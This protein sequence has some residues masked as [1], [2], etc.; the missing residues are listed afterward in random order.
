MLNILI[1]LPGS[2][3]TTYAKECIDKNSNAI[4]I[5]SDSIRK[6]LYGDES[7][8]GN[9][10]EV[11]SLMETRTIETLKNEKDVYYDAT[12]MTRKDRAHIISVCKDYEIRAVVV[13]STYETCVERDKNRNR[14]VGED[15]IKRMMKRFQAP[16]YDEG[17]NDITVVNTD[18]EVYG[19]SLGYLV[20]CLNNM[21]ISHDNPHHILSIQ[22]HCTK[23]ADYIRTKT[24]SKTLIRAALYHDIGKP[25][26]KD[27]HDTHGNECEIAH[28][29]CHEN[30]SAWMVYGINLDPYMAWLVSSHMEP[31]KNS[32]YYRK[33]SEVMKQ[34]LDLLHEADEAAH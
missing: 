22:E 19:D 12:N 14:T 20:N 10:E 28:Y 16:Y 5:S 21:N 33:L 31:Y 27:Y 30:V 29:Y 26:C 13:W 15:V 17:I 25:F 3:K 8:K 24:C 1:G 11:F 32:K 9:N 7:I 2:G 18:F 6:E 4:H 34:E 23:A